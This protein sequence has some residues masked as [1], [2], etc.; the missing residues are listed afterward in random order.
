MA[1]AS[2]R[3]G[4]HVVMD[5]IG[6]T[7]AGGGGKVDGRRGCKSKRNVSRRRTGDGDTCRFGRSACTLPVHTGDCRERCR[8]LE[9]A[10][11]TVEERLCPSETTGQYSS[12]ESLSEC[13]FKFCFFYLNFSTM[14]DVFE[15]Y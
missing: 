10:L 12:E 8:A 2:E 13:V 1:D 11:A 6:G 3:I 7:S 15:A 4:S 9:E 5:E 14:P